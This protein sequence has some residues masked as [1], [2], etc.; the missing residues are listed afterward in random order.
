MYNIQAT[1]QEGPT[2]LDTDKNIVV[3]RRDAFTEEQRKDII[4]AMNRLGAITV[5]VVRKDS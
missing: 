1:F 3:L 4:E 2:I 5:T